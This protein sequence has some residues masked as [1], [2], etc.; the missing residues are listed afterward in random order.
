MTPLSSRRPRL[1]IIGL[2]QQVLMLHTSR[3]VSSA[4]CSLFE[5]TGTGS[6]L[7]T[8][9]R[10]ARP[11]EEVQIVVARWI[12]HKVLV[13]HQLWT[14]LQVSGIQAL[15]RRLS[16][17]KICFRFLVFR[18]QQSPPVTWAF[19]CPSESP[20]GDPMTCLA[21]KLSCGF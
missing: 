18:T 15:R 8:W 7:L 10:S 12:E 20:F 4:Y 2:P 3:A 13:G 6:R 19:F 14:D 16:T 11:F 17:D 5:A 1:K 9:G 21:F